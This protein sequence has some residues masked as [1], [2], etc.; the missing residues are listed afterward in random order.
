MNF[1]DVKPIK[2]VGQSLDVKPVDVD[3]EMKQYDVW[4]K[5]RQSFD[6]Y[7]GDPKV[8][9]MNFN[10]T[11][12]NQKYKVRITEVVLNKDKGWYESLGELVDQK[13]IEPIYEHWIELIEIET[14]KSYVYKL[15]NGVLL[16]PV[17]YEEEVKNTME[18]YI[19]E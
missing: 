16:S 12:Q 3:D 17:D 2:W 11:G 14:N 7:S 13:M 9:L 8:K 6:Y 4:V 19:N 18:K 15:V 5:S 10:F 1:S